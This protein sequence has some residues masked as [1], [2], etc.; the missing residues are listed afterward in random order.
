MAAHTTVNLLLVDQ[1]R[2]YLQ[3]RGYRKFKEYPKNPQ[4]YSEV[5]DGDNVYFNIQ[6]SDGGFICWVYS[7]KTGKF[8]GVDQEAR[9]GMPSDPGR[10]SALVPV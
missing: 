2:N 10:V 9:S 6:F 8:R 3:S 1:A 4:S 5:T 7:C